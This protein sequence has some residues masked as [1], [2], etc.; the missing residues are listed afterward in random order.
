MIDQPDVSLILAALQ[1]LQTERKEDN[2]AI[3]KISPARRYYVQVIH[4]T[5]SQHFYGEAVSNRYLPSSLQL[6]DAQHDRLL[7]LGWLPPSVQHA[8]FYRTWP[9]VSLSDCSLA[10]SMILH[11]LTEVYALRPPQHI[12][13]NVVIQ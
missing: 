4:E 8:N 12:D 7:V 9:A 3:F 10:A 11:T 5:D 1:R 13:I 6:T 2:F